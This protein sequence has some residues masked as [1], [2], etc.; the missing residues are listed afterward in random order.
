MANKA[1]QDE[2]DG[3]PKYCFGWDKELRQAWRA[4]LK[5]VTAKG[6]TRKEY[7]CE[8]KVQNDS[9]VAVFADRYEW[10]VSDLSVADFNEK[11][12]GARHDS[13]WEGTH[14]TSHDRVAVRTRLDRTPLM[15][16][17]QQGKQIFQVF[18]EDFPDAAAAAAFVAELAVEFTSDRLKKEQI[19]PEAKRRL[20]ERGIKR[21]RGKATCICPGRRGGGGGSAWKQYADEC[22]IATIITFNLEP[23]YVRFEKCASVDGSLEP[24]SDC[25]LY[26]MAAVR[27]T[28]RRP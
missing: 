3:D 8:V 4:P 9:V 16:M 11:R 17:Y 1:E 12:G 24:T 28:A 19:K 22:V 27:P 13:W 21:K 20:L 6:A 7:S 18:I 10:I 23:I 14:T 2:R 15:S 5:R 25:L 26:V